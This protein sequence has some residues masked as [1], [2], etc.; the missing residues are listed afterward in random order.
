MIHEY[1]YTALLIYSEEIE[2]IQIYK[3]L[4]LTLTYI[5]NYRNL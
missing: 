5:L 4:N 3:N 2:D 1:I